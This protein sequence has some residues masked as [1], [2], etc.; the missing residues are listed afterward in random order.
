MNTG[1]PDSRSSS[2]SLGQEEPFTVD[3][4]TGVLSTLGEE[5]EQIHLSTVSKLY[6]FLTKVKGTK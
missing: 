6:L 5:G 4:L 2:S 3:P 1:L